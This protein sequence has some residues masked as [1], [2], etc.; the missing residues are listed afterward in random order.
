MDPRFRITT[1]PR[2]PITEVDA[3]TPLITLAWR[4]LHA[5]H[6]QRARERERHDWQTRKLDQMVI[7]V[8]DEV[9]QLRRLARLA[10][11]G[12]NE[13]GGDGQQRSLLAVADRLEQALAN[14]DVDIVV[15]NAE[16]YTSELMELLENTA[17]QPQED[18]TEPR[19]AEVIAPAVLR[20]GTLLRMG[21]A[22]IAIPA[23]AQD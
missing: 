6:R 19:V 1:T 14:L 21:K 5:E 20:R 12:P 8:A 9:H 2:Q 4:G 22:V 7:V 10:S 16:P 18:L 23:A 3:E 15:P 13:I 17:Q 11:A